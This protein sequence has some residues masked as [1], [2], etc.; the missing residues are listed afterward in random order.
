MSS[1]LSEI[2]QR[3]RSEKPDLLDCES[4]NSDD[5]MLE[6]NPNHQHN[7]ISPENDI[8]DDAALKNSNA[9]LPT[10]VLDVIIEEEKI[11]IENE[12][13][14]GLESKKRRT[15]EERRGKRHTK[16]TKDLKD[17][18]E[19]NELEGSMKAEE[20][21][22]NEKSHKKKT[23]SKKKNDDEEEKA[24]KEPNLTH[25]L[26]IPLNFPELKT[27][28]TELM[29][30][31]MK[32]IDKPF[33]PMF[34]KQDM[35]KLH[36]TLCMLSLPS[37]GLKAKAA[38]IV[39]GCQE[40][41]C[42]L[43]KDKKFELN[44]SGVSA[45]WADKHCKMANVIFLDLVRNEGFKLLDE[46]SG[47]LIRRLLKEGLVTTQFLKKVKVYYDKSKDLY[48][49]EVY[50]VT[51][52]RVKRRKGIEGVG[53]LNLGETLKKYSGFSLKESLKIKRLD[54]STRFKED[55]EKFYMPLAQIMF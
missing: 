16:K 25:F 44:F 33:K 41:L 3:L 13:A 5:M 31:I 42:N 23:A 46:I 53:Q 9:Y 49:P 29:D 18:E 36:V 47:L 51:L 20:N 8:D 22:V 21:I 30:K 32:E 15:V 55:A 1:S 37:E 4:S 38:K 35:D 27:V 45:F 50:H 19:E 24:E 11:M 14:K 28:L 48:R 12:V 40:E 7:L 52:F 54:L 6:P 2:L 10:E 39:Q 43:I 34:A 17:T 26:S